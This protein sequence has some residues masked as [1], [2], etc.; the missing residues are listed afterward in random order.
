MLTATVQYEFRASH[1]I[2]G[3]PI[4]GKEHEHNWRLQVTFKRK[5]GHHALKDGMIHD[6]KELYT[7]IKWAADC[8]THTSLNDVCPVPSC[9]HL[10]RD[11]LIPT[12][13][14]ALTPGVGP[15]PSGEHLE[16]QSARLWENEKY[17][18]EWSS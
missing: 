16:I 17:Y 3:H 15:D 6:F 5:Q 18:C 2:P 11:Y 9:E 12:I 8:M 14:K 4:C 13:R 7:W 10:L 1:W